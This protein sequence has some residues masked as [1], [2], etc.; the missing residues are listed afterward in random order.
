MNA[1]KARAAWLV[2]LTV[3]G[4][5]IGG[6][7]LSGDGRAG[8]QKEPDH[9]KVSATATRP[10]G[11]GRQVVTV[12]LEI[13][14]DWHTYANP[15]KNDDLDGARTRV[16]VSSAK[17]LQAASVAYPPGKLHKYGKDTM[18]IYEGKV[19]IRATIQRAAGDTGPLDV[20]VDYMVCDV[21]KCI[22]GK[23]QLQI[24]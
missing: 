4:L 16:K 24:K 9:V 6:L 21:S 10:D 18:L 8:G 7:V 1:R 5:A 20:V 11:E 2:R 3:V 19:E 23:V 17:D 15:V 14:K 13:D 22:P 12:T